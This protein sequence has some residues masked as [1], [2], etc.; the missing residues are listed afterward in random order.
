MLWQV[1]MVLVFKKRE[2]KKKKNKKP[3]SPKSFDSLLISYQMQR[4]K[5]ILFKF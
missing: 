1:L 3:I 2:N 5:L 4:S